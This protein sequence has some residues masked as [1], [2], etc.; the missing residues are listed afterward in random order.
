MLAILVLVIV[1]LIAA[2]FAIS[3]VMNGQTAETTDPALLPDVG[4][5]G[6]FTVVDEDYTMMTALSYKYN[7]EE[8]SLHVD[9]SGK[10][11]LDGDD[12]FP[13]NQETVGQ[14]A[15][16]ISDYG[17]FARYNY[18][19]ARISAY[20]IEDPKFDIKATYYDG[21]EKGTT[22][23][24]HLTVG[25]QNSVSGYYYF[26]EE[27]DSYIY[28]VSDALFQYFSFDKAQLFS[29]VETP[30]P[31]LTDVIS[32]SVEYDGGTFE[33]TAENGGDETAA[34]YVIENMP[35]QTQ[36]YMS[37]V[38]EYGMSE[39]DGSKYGLDDPSMK[40]TIT[41][42]EYRSVSTAEGGTSAQIS[43]ERTFVMIFGDRTTENVDGKETEYVYM[44]DEGSGTVYKVRAYRF[45]GLL[46][47][48][49]GNGG[50][51]EE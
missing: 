17:G 51:D 8:I 33:Y 5:T 42:K 50:E 1:L 4:M 11:V 28:M 45:D 19:P 10:W 18:D 24:R 30:S 22:H 48:V 44:T 2:Y 25:A 21:D 41:Y 6:T 35:K 47:A 49:S 32:M 13:V 43:R 7:S 29:I 34:N 36:L 9:E 26:Y 37:D 14:M 23:S 3:S 38:A 46:N 20:G 40:I 27:G 31:L 12:K 16:A 39:A 15:Q